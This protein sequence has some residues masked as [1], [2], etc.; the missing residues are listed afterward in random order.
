MQ[1]ILEKFW[2]VSKSFS[3][4]VYAFMLSSSRR[5]QLFTSPQSPVL[6]EW[7]VRSYSLSQNPSDP[8]NGFLNRIFACLVSVGPC[9]IRWQIVVEPCSTT[10]VLWKYICHLAVVKRKMWEGHDGLIHI[11]GNDIEG[12]ITWYCPRDRRT[13][14]W[15]FLQY[16]N[17]VTCG[18]IAF[19]II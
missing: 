4:P 1:I 17:R 18:N 8:D 19:T 13:R 6:F 3:N 9:W 7:E 11:F 16:F 12:A 10:I 14:G 2:S 15:K 5:S